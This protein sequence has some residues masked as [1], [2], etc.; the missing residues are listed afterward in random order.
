MLIP[1]RPVVLAFL[2]LSVL[3]SCRKRLPELV[4]DRNPEQ[5]LYSDESQW[6]D[7]EGKDFRVAIDNPE[8][9]AHYWNLVTGSDE[10]RPDVIFTTH[11]VLLFNAGEMD[12]GDRIRIH[13]LMPDQGKLIAF[14]SV[15]KSEI[16][17][18]AVYPVQIVRVG[19]QDAEVVFR[20]RTNY[21]P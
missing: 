15:E 2:L 13:E 11:M 18:A 20:P 9:W 14:Y 7:E 10:D 8:M 6:R 1:I 21:S 4:P 17:G 12:P 3:P 5:L 19:K 16:S